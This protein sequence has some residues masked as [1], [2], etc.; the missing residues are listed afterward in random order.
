MDAVATFFALTLLAC[1][2]G[3]IVPFGK[4]ISRLE[5]VRRKHYAIGA[6]ASFI[7]M[8]ITIPEPTPEQLAARAEKDAEQAH[9]LVI[10][11]AEPALD[12]VPEYT[13]EDHSET[14]KLVGSDVFARLN[15]LEPAAIYAAASSPE[16]D[17]T[18]TGG[19]SDISK[20]GKPVWFVDCENGNR[21]MINMIQAE[22]TLKEFRAGKLAK[23]NI[24]PTC[25]TSTV[26]L[27]SMTPEER[28][29]EADAAELQKKIRDKEVEY[30]TYCDMILQE[31][32]VS[33][34]SLDLHRWEFGVSDNGHAVVARPFDSDNSFGASLRSRYRC[35][36]DAAADKIESFTITGPNGTQTV[37]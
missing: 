33:P 12:V 20:P 1:L 32:L 15:E 9:A 21:F 6:V 34:S 27:C 8:A 5:P 2:I 37:I 3:I 13:R 4:F 31:V 17:A 7:L 19:I 35:E 16:C 30:V 10:S 25:T 36:I 29:A 11:K 24:E 28:Q 22:A 26:R 18:T 14:Y 23:Q